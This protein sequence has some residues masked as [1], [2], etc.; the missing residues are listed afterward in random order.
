MRLSLAIVGRPVLGLRGCQSAHLPR[1]RAKGV[2]PLE[3]PTGL[4][5]HGIG[6]DPVA[7][8]GV[9]GGL[10]LGAS[11]AID[12]CEFMQGQIFP[13]RLGI[14]D[15]GH[16]ATTTL[17]AGDPGQHGD[18]LLVIPAVE[19]VL[20]LSTD[21]HGHGKQ[22]GAGRVRI[23]LGIKRTILGGFPVREQIEQFA[24]HG[25]LGHGVLFTLGA[26]AIAPERQVCVPGELL[27]VADIVHGQPFRV[28]GVRGAIP[29]A[30]LD[31]GQPETQ[32]TVFV[33]IPVVEVRGRQRCIGLHRN[34][35]KAGHFDMQNYY[36]FTETSQRE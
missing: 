35:E 2:M 4:V 30:I 19:I 21:R 1:G 24:V 26:N 16:V 8:G 27:H 6:H 33:V 25:N 11:Q 36:G 29:V 5:C 14:D 15:R 10:V 23:R 34:I 22:N 20:A 31:K 9:D 3:D 7:P 18:V 13:G 12:R 17:P 28:H 32:R